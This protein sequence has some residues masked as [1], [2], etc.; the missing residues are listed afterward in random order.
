MDGNFSN[1][2]SELLF[3]RSYSRRVPLCSR[4][5]DHIISFWTLSVPESPF[6]GCNNSL[7]QLFIQQLS[8][9]ARN[10]SKIVLLESCTRIFYVSKVGMCFM[11]N[12]SRKHDALL[13]NIIACATFG[14][15][16]CVFI[17][18]SLEFF[19]CSY[20]YVTIYLNRKPLKYKR[21]IQRPHMAS[22]MIDGKKFTT[23]IKYLY[24][25]IK[26]DIHTHARVCKEYKFYFTY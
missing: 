8:K 7:I 15:K 26:V 18:I 4:Y 10:Q 23:N 19:F 24:Q 21:A 14:G 22:I 9:S 17:D 16:M 20:K 6:L 13:R 12:S 11:W 2:C 1:S 3:L 5:I 25:N